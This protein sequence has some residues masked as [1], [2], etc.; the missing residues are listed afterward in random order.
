MKRRRLLAPAVLAMVLGAMSLSL[1]ADKAGK[2]TK[3]GGGKLY[4]VQVRQ[5]PLLESPFLLAPAVAPVVYGQRV[6]VLDRRGRDWW[7]VAPLEDG[8]RGWIPAAALTS[9]ELVLKASGKQQLKALKKAQKKEMALA[10]RSFQDEVERRYRE[11]HPD[12]E[13]GFAFLDQH[14]EVEPIYQ[15]TAQEIARFRSAGGLSEDPGGGP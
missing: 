8:T 11:K 4:T 2:K 7:L 12:L 9:V 10:G 3:G 14:V 13:R 6:R 15:P 5:H 1:A